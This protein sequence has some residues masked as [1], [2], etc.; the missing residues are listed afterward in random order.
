MKKFLLFLALVLFFLLYEVVVW[1]GAAYFFPG[2]ELLVLFIMTSL[3]LTLVLVYWLVSR[4]Q[5]RQEAG[6]SWQAGPVAAPATAEVAEEESDELKALLAQANSRLA[7]SPKLPKTRLRPSLADFPLYLLVGLEGTRPGELLVNSG[8]DYDLLAGDPLEESGLGSAPQCSFW[9]ADQVVFAEIS[10]TVFGEEDQWRSLLTLLGPKKGLFHA[11]RRIWT[12]E[13][14]RQN[15]HGVILVKT[16]SDFLGQP[17]SQALARLAKTVRD[18]LR[19]IGAA[20]HANFPVYVLLSESD[21][22]PCFDDFFS[23][24]N[25]EEEQQILGCS[26]PLAR[27]EEG[28]RELYKEKQS[29]RLTKTFNRLRRSLS[30]KRI[31]LLPREEGLERR[32]GI[33]EFPRELARMRDVLIAFFVEIFQPNPLRPNPLLRGFYFTGRREAAISP[34][35]GSATQIG[36]NI[37]SPLSSAGATMFFQGGQPLKVGQQPGGLRTTKWCFLGELFQQL[38]GTDR[39]SLDGGFVDHRIRFYRYAA[40]GFATFLFL[41]LSFGF[42]HSWYQNRAMLAEIQKEVEASQGVWASD[43]NLMRTLEGMET[44]RKRVDLLTNYAREGAPWGMRWFLYSGNEVEKPLRDMY[45]DRFHDFFL[46]DLLAAIAQTLAEVPLQ[47]GP[48]APLPVG[49]HLKAYRMITSQECTPDEPFLTGVLLSVWQTIWT[50]DEKEEELA[51]RQ[52][53]FYSRELELD[54]IFELPEDKRL[55]DQAQRYLRQLGGAE[56]RYQNLLAD[57]K[58]K[59]AEALQ[60]NPGIEDV[61]SVP[62]EL[63]L[64]FTLEGWEQIRAVVPLNQGLGEPC[65]EGGGAAVQSVQSTPLQSEFQRRYLREYAEAW[66]EYLSNTKVRGYRNAADA[67]RKLDTLAG[68]RSPLLELLYVIAYHTNLR[69]SVASGA[70]ETLNEAIRKTLGASKEEQTQDEG[71]SPKRVRE[72]FDPVHAVAPETLQ[73]PINER[74]SAYTEA[75]QSLRRAIDQV[76]RSSR[77]SSDY[78]Q[79]NTQANQAASQALGVVAQLSSNFAVRD[80][81]V[82][83][84]IKRLLEEPIR[85]TQRYIETNIQDRIATELNGQYRQLCQQI[86]PLRNRY[87]FNPRSETEATIQEISSVF[88]FE[89]GALWKFYKQHLLDLVQKDQGDQYTQNPD[90]SEPALTENFLRTFSQL[91]LISNVLFAGESFTSPQ[92]SYRLRPQPHPEIEQVTMILDGRRLE[93]SRDRPQEGFFTWPGAAGSQQVDITASVRGV[94]LTIASYEGRLRNN[95][96][97]I[98]F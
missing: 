19:R 42:I 36:A 80:L 55:V 97:V 50:T 1:V 15:L 91:A 74:N 24:I 81:E 89:G 43:G 68:N 83:R 3:A 8:L 4:T 29:K 66:K 16:I 77:S 48:S 40:L 96:S 32:A 93:S 71:W 64:E 59:A 27:V 20:F 63:Q 85:N 45:F 56:S 94:V 44:I 21:Q 38:A 58:Q 22:I 39:M 51:R 69:D 46:R 72:E 98:F 28:G 26:L 17:D 88:A 23:W 84:Q 25:S 10:D 12:S 37:D 49:K 78:E 30:Q 82:D 86:R 35:G 9:F 14:T 2:S 34:A 13:E 11:L 52:L 65:V 76:S 62:E 57:A 33:Y 79:L 54:K 90:R 70:V 61:L 7:L 87:P 92:M 6:A 18:R 60:L 47:P 5:K 95:F 75:L 73:S 41:I 31:D 67:A 53:N